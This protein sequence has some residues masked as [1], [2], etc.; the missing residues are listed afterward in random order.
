MT[1]STFPMLLSTV[2]RKRPDFTRRIVCATI[3]SEVA[4]TYATRTLDSPE[5]LADF[6]HQVV[7]REPDHEADKENV[8]VVMLNTR[9]SPICWNR[10]AIGTVNEATAHP[11]EILRPVLVA[12][13]YAFVLMHNHPSGDP[14]PSRADEQI[15]R[16]ISEVAT[17]M[18]I[19]MM[20]HVV[21]GQPAPG[22]SPYF[23]FR[24]SGTI[25]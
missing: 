23:S 1:Q 20:D 25:S 5:K 3:V 8:V 21:I 22:R 13:A 24:E 6:W 7:V 14:S 16:R 18:Q 12:G 15:T 9:L 17:L 19:R 11:R 10:V 2:I 4:K